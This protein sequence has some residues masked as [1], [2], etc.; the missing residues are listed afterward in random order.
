MTLISYDSLP[1]G[2]LPAFHVDPDALKAAW[3]LNEHGTPIPTR[4]DRNRMWGEVLRIEAEEPVTRPISYTSA[5]EVS[6]RLS[7]QIDAQLRGHLKRL[8]ACDPLGRITVL[9]MEDSVCWTSEIM[10]GTF[11][12]A[13]FILV[14]DEFE[15]EPLKCW[16][17]IMGAGLPTEV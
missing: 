14:Q 8:A 10:C 6:S 15:N 16:S 4:T 2:C 1:Y 5:V 7:A 9:I 17:H 12:F 13:A 3:Y 11:R